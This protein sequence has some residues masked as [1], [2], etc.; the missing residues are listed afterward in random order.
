MNWFLYR[1]LTAL[2]GPWED[3]DNDA[4]EKACQRCEFYVFVETEHE[5]SK[6]LSEGCFYFHRGKKGMGLRLR[7][8]VL[9]LN[10]VSANL[11]AGDCLRPQACLPDIGDYKTF[12]L[13]ATLCFWRPSLA[14]LM[15][16]R[17]PL[18]DSSLGITIARAYGIDALH[19]NA[20]G[21]FNFI[22]HTAFFRVIS[23][24]YWQDR[25]HDSQVAIS[26]LNA[27]LHEWYATERDRGASLSEIGELTLGMLGKD[28]FKAKGA[29]SVGCFR[30]CCN[31]LLPVWADRI[32]KGRELH[33]CALSLLQWKELLAMQPDVVPDAVCEQLRDWC[34]KHLV[35][36]DLAEIACKPKHHA[37]FHMTIR[38]REM[39]HPRLYA[40]WQDE[41]LNALVARLAE[42]TH[43]A[44]WERGIFKRLGLHHA[45][46]Q[47]AECV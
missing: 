24:P 43:G 21:V 7:H 29:E 20:L 47:T 22:T 12:K 5:R 17:N 45:L 15:N 4:H 16:K 10:E 34:I 26:H 9:A 28:G 19:N 33:A 30:F 18:L 23:A 44:T 40:T 14:T 31:A 13:P 25:A 1:Q 8:D 27:W 11:R 39:G 41:T 32:H 37:F 42:A 35:Q 6:L 38:I 3:H 2:V 46:M 36:L